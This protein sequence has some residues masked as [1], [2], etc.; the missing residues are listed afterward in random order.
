MDPQQNTPVSPE[1]TPESPAPTQTSPVTP[2]ENK[3]QN[4]TAP[5]NPPKP[6]SPK[7]LIAA[8]V[9]AVIVVA[10]LAFLLLSPWSPL[11]GAAPL[12][13]KLKV[14]SNKLVYACSV[15]DKEVVGKELAIKLDVNKE[16]ATQNFSFDPSNT[17]DKELD[18]IKTT[19]S[20]S[21]FSTCGLKLDRVQEGK[22]EA[23]TTSYINVSAALEQF[24]DEEKAK[25]AFNSDKDRAGDDI[26]T[27]PSYKDTSYFQKP[28]TY[29]KSTP[30]QVSPKILYKNMIIGLS[31]PVGNND[32]NG[33]GTAEKLDK[34]TKD[35]VDRI[36]K[37]EGDK[38][39]N[40]N[41]ANELG[42]NAFADACLSVN[43]RKVLLA[44]GHNSQLDVSRTVGTQAFAP[45]D[46]G[47]EAPKQ[48]ASSCAI[49]FR[50]QDEAD[51]EGKMSAEDKEKLSFSDKF[52][53]FMTTQIT[54]A[55]N[56]EKA[57]EILDRAKKRAEESKNKGE[58]KTT[59]GAQ[60]NDV[61]L[62]DGA[63]KITTKTEDTESE[64]GVAP[65]GSS[66]GTLYYIQ[67]G[68]YVYTIVVTYV[69]QEKPYASKTRDVS[70]DQAK[71]I[72]KE[73]TT[74]VKRAN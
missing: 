7:K 20:E 18:L 62:G 70:D 27:L 8:I 65:T 48:L 34:V 67:D 45:N 53:H 56:K 23:Q 61:T 17:K 38:P 9:A 6:K 51:A 74:A 32:E 13:P 60:I 35:L 58:N 1:P 29:S 59:E 30:A 49:G 40:F 69:G 54:V 42:G 41:K 11:L 25:N 16:G 24:A 63:F 68:A 46:E 31:A 26:K 3:P 50:T 64:M 22:G 36:A 71:R 57:K 12:G 33:E 37:N 4:V 2:D 14:G 15:L 39:K 73:L 47:G 52:P 28:L 55:E 44:L 10:G 72:L 21:V 43:Y 66:Q 19:G 5:D